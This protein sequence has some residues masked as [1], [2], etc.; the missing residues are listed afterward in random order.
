MD[1]PPDDSVPDMRIITLQPGPRRPEMPELALYEAILDQATRDTIHRCRCACWCGHT[2]AA[3]E[4]Q[5]WIDADDDDVLSF[6]WVCD[7][8]RLDPGAVRRRVAW[9]RRHGG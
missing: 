2:E 4:A 9:R 8:L 3:R 5:A 1:P 7:V 6:R